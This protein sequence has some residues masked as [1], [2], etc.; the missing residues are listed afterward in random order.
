MNGMQPGKSAEVGR[1]TFDK[2]RAVDVAAVNLGDVVEVGV[3]RVG[4][5]GGVAEEDHA[6]GGGDDVGNSGDDGLHGA[7]VI[8]GRPGGQ[9]G[10]GQVAV[11]ADAAAELESDAGGKIRILGVGAD[12]ERV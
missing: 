9:T 3:G 11:V 2:A 4:A 1:Q 5:H 7:G 8:V 6:V 10:A 12:G